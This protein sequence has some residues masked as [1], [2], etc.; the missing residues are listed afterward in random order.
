M[1]AHISSFRIL[2]RSDDFIDVLSLIDFPSA[3]DVTAFC[4][5]HYSLFSS[6]TNYLF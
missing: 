2:L 5:T 4:K 1:S 3:D 6:V